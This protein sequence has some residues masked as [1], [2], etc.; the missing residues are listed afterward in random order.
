MS[1]ELDKLIVN[2]IREEF[3]DD[4]D[5]II[6]LYKT[7]KSLGLKAVKQK[8]IEYLK[9]FGLEVTELE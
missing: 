1:T 8:I 4:S 5:F 6:E 9:S 3:R 7:Y 2:L